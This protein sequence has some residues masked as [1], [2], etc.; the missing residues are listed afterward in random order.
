M[1]AK[2]RE[3]LYGL[4][5]KH[6]RVPTIKG[7]PISIDAAVDER[8]GMVMFAYPVVA[9]FEELR[10]PPSVME[11][12]RLVSVSDRECIMG[13]R[14]Q[15]KDNSEGLSYPALGMM[16]M[17]FD[18]SAY[19]SDLQNPTGGKTLE[20]TIPIEISKEP[21]KFLALAQQLNP[22]LSCVFTNDYQSHMA[23]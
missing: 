20:L 12:I 8:Y 1:S 21:L 4:F 15:T 18:V 2:V 16:S 22:G 14:F 19:L 23:Q 7:Q 17:S 10:M 3:L 6:N 13:F 9:V 5:D 11:G